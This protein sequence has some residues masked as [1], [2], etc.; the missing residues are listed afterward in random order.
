MWLL[1][2]DAGDGILKTIKGAGIFSYRVQLND[3]LY[4]KW[5]LK[6]RWFNPRSTG[7]S[8]FSVINLMIYRV[9]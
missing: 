2:D 7:I 5:E 8:C 6:L 3:H 1:S 9:A 4:A